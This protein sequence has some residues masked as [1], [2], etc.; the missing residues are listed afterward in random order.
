MFNIDNPEYSMIRPHIKKSLVDYAKYN[1][2]TGGFL[3][4]VLENDL[5]GALGK[6]DRD[7]RENIYHIVKFVYN[8]LPASCWVSKEKVKKWEGLERY[9]KTQK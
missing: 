9:K 3:K 8:E 5:A 6:A 1:Y 4:S 2:S 7:N